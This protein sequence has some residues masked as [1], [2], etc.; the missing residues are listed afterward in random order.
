MLVS[1][2]NCKIRPAFVL[3]LHQYFG[4][5]EVHNGWNRKRKRWTNTT[6]GSYW[7]TSQCDVSSRTFRWADYHCVPRRE[8]A[9]SSHQSV[10]WGQSPGTPGPLW[11]E[12]AHCQKAIA[13]WVIF[14]IFAGFNNSSKSSRR[15][16]HLILKY[17][18]VSGLFRFCALPRF[19]ALYCTNEDGGMRVL[20]LFQHKFLYESTSICKENLPKM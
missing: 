7:S 4:I 2:I 10:G 1:L 11:G 19:L 8:N 9:S 5:I 16:L 18:I 15:C 20:G 6:R 13:F 3:T 17:G 14:E 12:R